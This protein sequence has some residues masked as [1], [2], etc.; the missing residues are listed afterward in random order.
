MGGG[1]ATYT[2]TNEKVETP[3]EDSEVILARD[4]VRQQLKD[5]L[6]YL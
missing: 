6:P 3:E 2:Q 4:Q 1:Q 5:G